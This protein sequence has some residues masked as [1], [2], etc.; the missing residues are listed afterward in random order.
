MFE[1]EKF[2][3]SFARLE[4]GDTLVLFTDGISDAVSPERDRFGFEGLERVV[5]QNTGATLEKLQTAILAA[6][7]DFTRGAPQADDITLL[8]LRFL[9]AGHSAVG[10]R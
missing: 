3:T 10:L 1:E 8:M 9:G 7:E 6:M 5:Q 2:K 4:L